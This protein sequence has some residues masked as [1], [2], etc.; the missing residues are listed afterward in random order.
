MALQ[1]Q[2]S[3]LNDIKLSQT[4]GVTEMAP[5]TLEEDQPLFASIASGFTKLKPKP[6][7]ILDQNKKQEQ[8]FKDENIKQEQVLKEEQ[9]LDESIT[10]IEDNIYRDDADLSNMGVLN[11]INN[12]T[13][14]NTGY[15]N[16]KYIED[17]DGIKKV[18]NSTAER[19]KKNKSVSFDETKNKAE[20]YDWIKNIKNTDLFDPSV[21]ISTQITAARYVL[22]DSA[23]Q[24]NI[25][26][27]QVVDQKAKGI[28]DEQ[29]LL[30][31][32]RAMA[33]HSAFQHK[34]KGM[35][36]EVARSLNAFKIPIQTPG[37][38][39]AYTN[40]GEYTKEI[41]KENGGADTTQHLAERY[42]D[43]VNKNGQ[44]AGDKIAEKAW[45]IRTIEA[46]E[47]LYQGGLLWSTRTLF[48]N[49]FGSA[50]YS[51]VKIPEKVI[52]AA[53]RI[54]NEVLQKVVIN[55]IIN[56]GKKGIYK[57]RSLYNRDL[58]PGEY[59]GDNTKGD[60]FGKAFA[61]IQGYIESISEAFKMANY[62]FKTGTPSDATQRFEVS[63]SPK[64]S[65]EYL[66][67]T[68]TGGK[69]VD[70]IGKASGLPF[71]LMLWQDE[72]LKNIAHGANKREIAYD[73]YQETIDKYKGSGKTEGEI[74]QLA[75]DE[76]QK[77]IDGDIPTNR[78]ADLKE[79]VQEVV[80]QNDLGKIGKKIQALQ[81]VPSMKLLMPFV[82]TPI[83]IFKTFMK[84]HGVE[85]F[86]PFINSNKFWRDTKYRQSV[87]AKMS[88]TAS[89]YAYTS[90]LYSQGYITGAAPADTEQR[91]ALRDL[92]WQPFSFVFRD[93]N[94]PEGVAL[95]DDR[96]LPTGNHK[97]MSYMGFEPIG[98][99][100][101]TSAT[102][103]E[104]LARTKDPKARD[105]LYMAWVGT[106]Y[107]TFKEQPYIQAVASLAKIA[108]GTYANFSEFSETILG[109][110]VPF[111]AAVK[112]VDRFMD[113]TVKDYSYA[114]EVDENEFVFDDDGNLVLNED[115]EPV[116]NQFYGLP[117]KY[118]SVMTIHKGINKVISILPAV[119][120]DTYPVLDAFGNEISKNYGLTVGEKAWNYVMPLTIANGRDEIPYEV[121]RLGNPLVLKDSRY[122][123]MKLTPEQNYFLINQA[124]NKTKIKRKDFETAIE[125]LIFSR[126]YQKSNNRE[127]KNL[128]LAVKKDYYDQAFNNE[129]KDEF[130]DEYEIHKKRKEYMLNGDINSV[131][132]GD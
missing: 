26:A 54:P 20:G 43:A 22:T 34:F 106:T 119:P 98:A 125:V 115:G 67:I 113:G 6:K 64:F 108:D 100:L 41:L 87:M 40:V 38:L 31:F 3:L 56:T 90:Y 82:K 96:G 97:Y 127:K 65:S 9:K 105:N 47:E 91:N 121:V 8:V 80:F 66:G 58:M 123:G 130:Y 81:D 27:K 42:L 30:D 19:L 74:N 76:A 35:Q 1:D 126:T 83:N 124:T 107:D 25:L 51:A 112:G 59:W 7:D 120:D 102:M 2:E 78:K 12:A 28:I 75:L 49:F 46:V 111:S 132:F 14:E 129:F 4:G 29:L 52:G 53:L 36:S 79:A 71:K 103:W 69:A 104:K 32:R 33:M 23:N 117:T 68:G 21:P 89:T 73:V 11:D 109:S 13:P 10:Q 39:G 128:L 99:I 18:L 122:D 93:P 84:Y 77:V 131:A 72:F 17:N 5:S 116:I 60:D 15:I 55:P 50:V 101:G 110:F 70:Y 44:I 37:S 88:V 63:K 45:G 118:D 24:L 114:F 57:F 48:R 94:L 61:Y 16:F 92:G 85:A 95:F 86:N 62:A